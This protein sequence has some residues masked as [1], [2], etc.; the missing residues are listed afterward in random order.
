[1]DDRLLLSFVNCLALLAEKSSGPGRES[2]PLSIYKFRRAPSAAALL[3]KTATYARAHYNY[4]LLIEE[5]VACKI[6]S[7]E[8][9]FSAYPHKI[10]F[11]NQL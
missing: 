2:S 6:R 8:A 7:H 4:S 5:D 11:T 10:V 9:I 3:R 1:M